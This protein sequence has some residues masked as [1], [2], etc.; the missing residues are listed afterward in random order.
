MIKCVYLENSNCVLLSCNEDKWDDLMDLMLSEPSLLQWVG[1]CVL[2]LHLCNNQKKLS[3]SK[4]NFSEK[5]LELKLK[6]ILITILLNAS[7]KV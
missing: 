3:I 4:N 2:S 6:P 1:E 7:I 5:K